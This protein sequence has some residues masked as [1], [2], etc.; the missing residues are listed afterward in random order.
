L[1]DL[2]NY[3]VLNGLLT[4]KSG[5]SYRAV[6]KQIVEENDLIFKIDTTFEL[7]DNLEFQ[8]YTGCFYKVL[9]PKQLSQLTTRHQEAAERIS[10]GYE[11]NVTPRLVAQ[12][13]LD[14]L[15]EDDFELE[16]YRVS[17]LLAFYRVSSP[18]P[19]LNLGLPEFNGTENSNIETVY[20]NLNQNNQIE[21]DKRTLTNE[22]AEQMIY[23]F[24]SVKPE[25]RGIEFT[26]S[27]D[28]SYESYLKTTEMFNSIYSKLKSEKGDIPKNI[29]FKEPK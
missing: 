18:L 22:Q 11:G 14:N 15:A 27:K 5:A 6:Y 7:L 16:F 13:I 2:E 8:V 28:A 21:I 25:M 3:F 29:I 4:D 20:V 26:A 24:L 12:R 9:T 1:N 19:T 17:S 23:E 10:G